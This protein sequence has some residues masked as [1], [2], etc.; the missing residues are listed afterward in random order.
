TGFSG[1][2]LVSAGVLALALI[3]ALVVV[4]VRRSDLT[5]AG[6]TS[7]PEPD[8]PPAAVR[9]DENVDLSRGG[10]EVT[11]VV[12][13]LHPDEL[14]G[15]GTGSGRPQDRRDVYP[16]VTNR[17]KRLVGPRRASDDRSPT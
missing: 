14:V 16:A 3:V 8:E 7:L 11:R 13:A 17:P 2:Y 4:R 6:P 9:H 1:G 5:G 10:I 15:L 12:R